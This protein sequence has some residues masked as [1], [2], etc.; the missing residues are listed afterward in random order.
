[1]TSPARPPPHTHTHTTR[2]P[3]KHRIEVERADWIIYITDMGQAQHF[4]LVR[5]AEQGGGVQGGGAVC[6][7]GS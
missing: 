3:V 2:P 1:M 7:V 4:D 6:G 5:G